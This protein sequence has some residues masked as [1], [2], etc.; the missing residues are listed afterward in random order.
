MQCLQ[1]VT[2]MCIKRA[3]LMVW[4]LVLL[5]IAC[6]IL[7]HAAPGDST[8]QNGKNSN[9]RTSLSTQKMKFMT[10]HGNHPK[11]SETPPTELSTTQPVSTEAEGTDEDNKMTTETAAPSEEPSE[12]ISNSDGRPA[13]I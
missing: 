2:T 11:S 4:G 3:G 1:R 8:S 6:F 9:L 7:T 10:G 12:R 5:T 13:A